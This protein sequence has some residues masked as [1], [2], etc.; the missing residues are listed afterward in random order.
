MYIKHDIVFAT[1]YIVVIVGLC[2]FLGYNIESCIKPKETI[3]ADTIF[4]DRIIE[5]PSVSGGGVVEKS[6][7]VLRNQP[8]KEMS[9]QVLELLVQRDSLTALLYRDSVSV[10]VF[11]NDVVPET[12]DTV[13]I[14]YDE[15]TAQ[16][17]Y[18]IR[19][20]PRTIKVE[21]ITKTITVHE[22]TGFLEKALL[23]VGGVGVGYIMNG[24]IR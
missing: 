17:Q 2:S 7:P 13:S 10:S 3:K 20:A 5:I 19:F 4:V 24:V 16:L 22:E 23:V 12:K 11:L 21:Q 8:D 14:T 15:I 6:K 9:K 1:I 18:N